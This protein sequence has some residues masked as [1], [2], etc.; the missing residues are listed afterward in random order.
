M[1]LPQNDPLKVPDPALGRHIQY[2]AQLQKTM[3]LNILKDTKGV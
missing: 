2:L 1:A 3:T